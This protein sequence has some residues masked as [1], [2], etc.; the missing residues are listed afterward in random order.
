MRWR[1][2]G[3]TTFEHRMTLLE[4]A[5]VFGPYLSFH[6][7]IKRLP[8]GR[9]KSKEKDSITL[10]LRARCVRQVRSTSHQDIRSRGRCD[11]RGSLR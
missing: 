10:L 5:K 6:L 2:R 11:K 7:H 9:Q 8:A 4:A 1:D 3:R